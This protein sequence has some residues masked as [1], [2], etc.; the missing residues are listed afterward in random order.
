MSKNNLRGF[1][2]QARLVKY[3]YENTQRQYDEYPPKDDIVHIAVAIN[4]WTL[5]CGCYM[6]IEQTMKLLIRMGGGN[7]KNIH[8]LNR[9]YSLLDPSDRDVVASYYR[10]YRSLH[11]FD[12][13]SVSLKTADEFIL[14]IGNGYV[15]WRYILAEDDQTMP[16]MH[17]GLMLEIWRALADLVEHKMKTC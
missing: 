7:P 4:A 14:Y 17:V 9:L 8:D 1:K 11:N 6:G 5:I 13:S 10:V 3:A 15:K 12:T 16:K 2:E